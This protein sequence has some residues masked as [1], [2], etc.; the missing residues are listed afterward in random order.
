MDIPELWPRQK[1]L[2]HRRDD[3]LNAA[4]RRVAPQSPISSYRPRSHSVF[5]VAPSRFVLVGVIGVVAFAGCS[6]SHGSGSRRVVVTATG[7]IGPLHVDRSERADVISFAGRPESERRGRYIDYLPFDALGYGC[8]GK[9]VTD[10]AGTPRCKTIF[11][12]DARS[13]R[14]AILYTENARFTD[15]RGIHVG[16]PTAVAERLAHKR[17]ISGCFDG[18][19]FP[20][21]SA[22]LVMWFY[23]GKHVVRHRLPH[24]VGGHVGLLVVHSRRLNPGV[25]DC[26]DS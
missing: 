22:F 2:R 19:G 5:C 16:T 20:T 7:R 26:I 21:K 25:L 10:S 15:V 24:L 14:L 1:A 13:G 4:S 9:R 8:K 3:D 12:L 17:V 18:F 6:S 11:Y 23:G